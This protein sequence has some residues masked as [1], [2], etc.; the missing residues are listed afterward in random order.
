MYRYKAFGLSIASDTFFP[1]LI[2]DDFA[3]DPEVRIEKGEVADAF[4]GE[5]IQIHNRKIGPDFFTSI[6]KAFPAPGWK[7]VGR[8]GSNPMRGPTWRK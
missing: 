1:E 5:A 2:R 6:R 8:Y 7:R 3:G 4:D